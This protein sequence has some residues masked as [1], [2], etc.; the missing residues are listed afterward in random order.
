MFHLFVYKSPPCHFPLLRLDRARSSWRI[1]ETPDP[2]LIPY[3]GQSGDGKVG[4]DVISKAVKQRQKVILFT[5]KC[6]HNYMVNND[7]SNDVNNERFHCKIQCYVFVLSCRW[8][9]H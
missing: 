9:R 7:N 8:I 2:G 3:P 5:L 6:S 1:V 4:Y